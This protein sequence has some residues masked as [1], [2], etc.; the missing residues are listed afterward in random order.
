MLNRSYSSQ[1]LCV[2]YLASSPYESNHA[3]AYKPEL[4]ALENTN[5]VFLLRRKVYPFLSLVGID[6]TPAKGGD[7]SNIL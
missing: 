2:S 3:C 4:G 6:Y 7:Q 5:S 1:H